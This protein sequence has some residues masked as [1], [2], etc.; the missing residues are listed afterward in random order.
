MYNIYYDLDNEC[1]QMLYF[2]VA[3][4][5]GLNLIKGFGDKYSKQYVRIA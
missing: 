3:E 2:K 1:D 5:Q 4:F